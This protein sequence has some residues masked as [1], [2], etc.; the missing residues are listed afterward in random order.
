[1]SLDDAV[2]ATERALS[3][4]NRAR[5]DTAGWDDEK[6]REFDRLSAAP[7]ERSG[8]DLLKALARARESLERAERLLRE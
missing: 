7:L 3:A 6:R 4:L 8:K 5:A 2:T 1:M